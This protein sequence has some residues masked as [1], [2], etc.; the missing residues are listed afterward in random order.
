MLV[1]GHPRVITTR[2]MVTVAHHSPCGPS[3]QYKVVPNAGHWTRLSQPGYRVWQILSAGYFGPDLDKYGKQA[4]ALWQWY[5]GETLSGLG[6]DEQSVSFKPEITNSDRNSIRSSNIASISPRYCHCELTDTE[7]AL[8]LAP[9]WMSAWFSH[10]ESAQLSPAWHLTR[11]DTSDT[12]PDTQAA[13]AAQGRLTNNHNS[14]H[15]TDTGQGGHQE[16]T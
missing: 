7:W 14:R 10:P 13:Q 12:F 1:S 11:C 2:C 6:S 5:S 9:P 15:N 3:C 8:G 4:A 16:H